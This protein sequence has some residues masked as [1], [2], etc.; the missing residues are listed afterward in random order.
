MGFLRKIS[1]VVTILLLPGL[2][3]A[4]EVT[5][6]S[7][8]KNLAN[9]VILNIYEELLKLKIEIKELSTFGENSLYENQYKM[10]TILYRQNSKEDQQK[11]RNYEVGITVTKLDDSIFQDEKGYFVYD[12]PFLNVKIAGF[13]N[14][15]ASTSEYD[16]SKIIDR[17]LTLLSDY[18]QHFLPLQLYLI[19]SKEVFK[20]GERI[21]FEVI[22]KNVSKQNLVVK[23][24]GLQ[25]LFFI[26]NNQTWGA[27]QVTSDGKIIQGGQS[28]ILKGG[29][30]L[31]MSFRGD[32]FV[33]PREFEI[34]CLYK[35]AISGVQPY[36]KL[37]VKIVSD[38]K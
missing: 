4:E 5:I 37:R 34:F 33:V 36:G 32:S 25:T 38:K 21:E 26:F 2:L 3:W 12:F 13:E 1:F 27:E 17:Y 23:E 28:V 30:S 11:S 10:Y 9:K 22:L 14:E 18:Q 19:P 15:V 24:F 29:E 6:D 16:L 31:R 35:M 8:T 7:Q 20:T